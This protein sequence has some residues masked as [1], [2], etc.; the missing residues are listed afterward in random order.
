MRK[1]NIT[2]FEVFVLIMLTLSFK[3]FRYFYV[4]KISQNKHRLLTD[5]ILRW[6]DTIE[7]K[8]IQQKNELFF[9]GPKLEVKWFLSV[10]FTSARE[11]SFSAHLYNLSLSTRVNVLVLKLSNFPHK[12]LF[13]SKKNVKDEPRTV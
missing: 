11:N 7:V 9:T 10:F 5:F 13:S 1:N 2:I 3:W 8:K 4:N 12:I 6:A